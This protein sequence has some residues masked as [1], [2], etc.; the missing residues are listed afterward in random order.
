MMALS[1]AA[2]G[3]VDGGDHHDAAGAHELGAAGEEVRQVLDVL[4]DF[5]V[6]HGVEGGAAGGEVVGGDELVVDGGAA[7]VGVDFGD[8]DVFFGDLCA[9]N[10]G[11]EVVDGF[12]EDA[13]AAADVEDV[14]ALEGA[15]GVGVAGEGG[16]EAVADVAESEG[17]EFVQGP[18]GALFVPPAVGEFFEVFDFAR[19]DVGGGEVDGGHGGCG[20]G[21]GVLRWISV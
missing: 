2:R 18:E 1:Q 14:E 17:V 8:A 10:F 20:V 19:V 21:R 13:A 12:A 3:A 9:G 7:P 11:A 5:H 4:D 16:A 6:E 15:L